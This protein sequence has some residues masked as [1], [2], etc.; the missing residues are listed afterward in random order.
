MESI[1]HFY[2]A[3]QLSPTPTPSIFGTVTFVNVIILNS[4]ET[5]HGLS[6]EGKNTLGC[7]FFFFFYAGKS[8]EKAIGTGL[9][10]TAVH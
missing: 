6:L 7:D 1:H 10:D 8:C 4:A 3:L 2:L 5:K 9:L